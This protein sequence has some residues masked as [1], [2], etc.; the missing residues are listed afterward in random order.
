MIHH[1]IPWGEAVLPPKQTLVPLPGRVGLFHQLPPPR[2]I[3]L[4]ETPS[5]HQLL[6]EDAEYSRLKPFTMV[7][8]R[9]QT[10]GRGQ[11]GNSWESEDYKNLTFSMPVIPEGIAP[12]GQFTLSEATALSVVALLQE[13]GITAMVKWPNDIYVGERKICG[14]LI[15]NALKGEK[16]ARSIISAGLNVNQTIFTS[17]APN[18]TSMLLERRKIIPTEQDMDVDRLALRLLQILREMIGAC[19]SALGR[20][21]IHRAYMTHLFR[22]DGKAHEFLDRR[23]GNRISA[24]IE[25][26]RPDGPISLR[27]AATGER[28]EP[29]LFKEI[30]HLPEDPEITGFGADT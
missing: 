12:A 16:I 7:A 19:A 9:R 17:D 29:Y 25:D 1:F 5:T 2:I 13:E 21:A 30:A 3:F 15:D 14:I 20:E 24:V 28:P 6:K 26:V 4:E 18:P 8:A 10:S 11:R 23:T 27:I 22:N